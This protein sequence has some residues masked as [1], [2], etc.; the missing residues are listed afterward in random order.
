MQFDPNQSIDG[1]VYS[2][3]GMVMPPLNPPMPQTPDQSMDHG[4]AWHDMSMASPAWAHLD[5]LATGLIATPQTRSTRAKQAA[6]ARGGGPRS[7]VKDA[8]AGAARSLVFGDASGRSGTAGT[9]AKTGADAAGGAGVPASPATMF[10]QSR[11]PAAKARDGTGSAS[12]GTP[13]PAET[14]MDA[15]SHDIPAVVR[16]TPEKVEQPEEIE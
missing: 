11:S 7:N 6:T 3:D 10:A 2:A 4:Q 5:R 1:S 13:N 9:G 15:I 12:G 8:V 16:S 14:S